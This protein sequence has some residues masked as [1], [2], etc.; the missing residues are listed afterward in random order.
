MPNKAPAAIPARQASAAPSAPDASTD[1]ASADAAS[2]AGIAAPG[3]RPFLS[4]VRGQP[5]AAELAAVVSVLAARASPRRPCPAPARASGSSWSDRS[6]L[7]RES[8]APGPAPGGAAPCRAS[9][10]P[11][12]QPEHPRQVREPPPQLL[13]RRIELRTEAL[14]ERDVHHVVD[15]PIVISPRQLERP[16]VVRCGVCRTDSAT[17]RTWHRPRRRPRR[18]IGLA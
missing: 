14:G 11:P 12:L 18:P 17:A 4:V 16:L 3:T 10:R 8:I 13:V 9:R 6:R 5:T 1:D 2:A 15:R 7:L